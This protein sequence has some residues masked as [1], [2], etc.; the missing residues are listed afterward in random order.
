MTATA[1]GRILP[2]RSLLERLDSHGKGLDLMVRD[3]AVL[4]VGVVLDERLDLCVWRVLPAGRPADKPLPWT[5]EQSAR[6]DMHARHMKVAPVGGEPYAP[7]SRSLPASA[8]ALA[9]PMCA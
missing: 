9:A 5:H 7:A 1:H 6:H 2:S 4:D 3:Q 8:A